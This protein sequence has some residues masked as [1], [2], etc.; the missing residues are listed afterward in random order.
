MPRCKQAQTVHNMAITPIM[1]AVRMAA[2]AHLPLIES[3]H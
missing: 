3:T 1:R 2:G